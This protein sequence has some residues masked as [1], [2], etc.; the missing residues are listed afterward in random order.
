MENECEVIRQQ[1]DETRSAMTD[2][3]ETL[4]QQVVESVQAASAAVSETVQS[5]TDSVHE[6]V[7][8]VKDTFDLPRQVDRRPWTMMAGATALGY[9]GG[10]LLSRTNGR[11]ARIIETFE[12][13]SPPVDAHIPASGNGTPTGHAPVASAATPKSDGAAEKT[14]WRD[15]FHTEITQLEGLAVGTLFGIVRDI[16]T[17]AAPGSMEHQLEEIVNGITVKLGGRVL[18]GPILRE[19]SEMDGITKNGKQV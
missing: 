3:M 5:V 17:K 18:E 4:E 1:M 8:T 9:F 12:S 19:P 2:K 7:E 11:D 16:V 13:A 14:G 15:T 10:Y 6:T